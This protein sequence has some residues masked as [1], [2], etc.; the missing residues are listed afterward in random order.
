VISVT[1]NTCLASAPGNVLLTV[2]ES[3]LAHE[4]VANVSQVVTIGKSR[5]DEQVGDFPAAIVDWI[6]AGVRLV[7]GL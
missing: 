2:A 6:E 7:L 1:A 5:L 4:S 3:G